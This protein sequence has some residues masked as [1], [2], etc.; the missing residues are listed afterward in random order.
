[1]LISPQMQE[2]LRPEA[3]LVVIL[4]RAF[5]SYHQVVMKWLMTAVK[6]QHLKTSPSTAAG[7]KGSNLDPFM[8]CTEQK[9][10]RKKTPA[11]TGNLNGCTLLQDAHVQRNHVAW[12]YES[13]PMSR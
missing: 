1:M 10:K 2:Q 9:H 7:L 5:H 3:L 11:Q 4:K 13:S 6:G 8:L 12:P